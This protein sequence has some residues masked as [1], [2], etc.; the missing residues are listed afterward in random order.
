MSGGT[1]VSGIGL[2]VTYPVSPF[3]VKVPD[4]AVGSWTATKRLVTTSEPFHFRRDL[5]IG[6]VSGEKGIYRQV[7]FVSLIFANLSVADDTPGTIGCQ[8]AHRTAMD[9]LS[10]PGYLGFLS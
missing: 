6:R 7:S 2:R 8:S 3:L 1:S 9:K 5:D 10:A 4:V